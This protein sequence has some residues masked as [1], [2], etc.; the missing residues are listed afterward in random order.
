MDMT[1]KRALERTGTATIGLARGKLTRIQNGRGLTLRVQHGAVWVTQS[2][3]KED[4]YLA[5]GDAFVLDR[6]GLTLVSTCGRSPFALVA[7]VPPTPVAAPRTRIRRS[8]FWSRWARLQ[9]GLWKP[10]TRWA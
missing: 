4:T 1:T 6:D 2:G 7:L 10:V 3:S 8:D 9:R 5:A